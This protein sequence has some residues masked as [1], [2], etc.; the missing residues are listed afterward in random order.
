MNRSITATKSLRL[1]A[2]LAALVVGSSALASTAANTTITNQATVTYNDASGTAQTPVSASAS[3]T[4]TLV[5]SA[6]NITSP[7]NQTI[8][9]GTSATL[10]Y[11]ITGTANG[12]DTY[13]LASTATPSSLTAVTP[14]LPAT[15]I[16]GGTTLAVAANVGD[17]T[18]TVPYDGVASNAS[19]NGL[20]PNDVIV[21]GGNPY[22]IAA[23]GITKNAGAN[24]AVITLTTN[25][26]GAGQAVGTVVGERQTFTETVP[27]GTVTSGT[28]GTQTVSTK[29][30]SQTSAAATVTQATPTVITVNKPALTVTKT[31]STDGGNTFAA[32]ANA[33]P[34]STLVY[35]IVAHN[36]GASD[37]TS[38]AFTDVVPAYLTYVAN[39]GKYAVSTATVYSAA[40]AVNDGTGGYSYTA[41][42]T[43]VAFDPNSAGNAVSTVSAGADLVLFFEV[44]IN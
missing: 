27:S 2:A 36:A 1:L 17:L 15:V 23:G 25:I 30:T 39:S 3:V 18:I 19:I 5:P 14:A 29:A 41:G 4:V 44:T 12:P 21:I 40:T 11:T 28:S 22:T 31:V 38:V 20:A 6:P 42:T 34:G 32:S 10:S 13:N 33:A 24:N 26:A 7:A 16:L 35:K 9:Q 8:A 37:A 43:T